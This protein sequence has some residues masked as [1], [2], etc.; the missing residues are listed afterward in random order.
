LVPT[1]RLSHR[2]T[3]TVRAGSAAAKVVASAS[4]RRRAVRSSG[5]TSSLV[6]ELADHPRPWA[7]SRPS[8]PFRSSAT[9]IACMSGTT[10]LTSTTSNDALGGG[11]RGRRR[12]R[13]H[14]EWRMTLRRRSAI[15]RLGGSQACDRRAPHAGRRG[16][17]PAPRRARGVEVPDAPRA[18]RQFAG[19]CGPRPGPPRR[20]RCG[21]P[22]N[23]TSQPAERA[24]P[25]SSG[26]VAAALERPGQIGPDP[27]GK[28]PYPG[29]AGPY[30]GQLPGATWV[31]SPVGWTRK[32]QTSQVT[33]LTTSAPS[34]TPAA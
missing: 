28:D 32:I 23:G 33:W 16:V 30:P 3:S 22:P 4:T 18:P 11:W 10:D 20:V 24:R 5:R 6:T 29:F 25:D 14:L 19:A 2:R 15:P 7:I 31:T 9:S 1:G 21:R 27:P 8:R 26:V 17:G 12:N 34:G 13:A